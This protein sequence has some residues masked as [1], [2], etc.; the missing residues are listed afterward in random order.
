MKGLKVNN[1]SLLVLGMKG[2]KV[3][4]SSRLVL[5]INRVKGKYQQSVSF[6]H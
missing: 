3:N 4:I 1:I 5:G 2:L 6:R